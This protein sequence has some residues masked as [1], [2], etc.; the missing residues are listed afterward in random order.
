[1]AAPF[2]DHFSDRSAAYAQHRPGYPPALALWLAEQAPSR[3][4]A[5]DCGCGSGQFSTL[6]AEAFERVVALDASPQQ[7]ANASPHPRVEYRVATG[8]DTGLPAAS[9]D[10]L[11][12]AQAAHWFDLDAFYAEAR[13][14]LRPGGVIAL[15]TY[16]I[17]EI[18][19]DVGA[20]MRR[21]Y[22]DVVGPFWPP[23]RR[24]VESG[25]RELPFPFDET[26]APALAMTARW[27]LDDLLGYVDTWSAVRA[28]E[29]TLGREPWERLAA[30]LRTIWGPPA[31]RREIRWPLSL[32]VGRV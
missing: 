12:V 3:G 23:E 10:L 18:D 20:L 14:V 5:L 19:G 1:M 31:E 32:R 30:E 21:F 25:Y 27:G 8:E 4:L 7:V 6:L 24:H 16:N 15:I 11:S 29:K 13:R 17:I 28:A 26:P 22:H 9:V 2:K